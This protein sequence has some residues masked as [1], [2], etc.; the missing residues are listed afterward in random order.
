MSWQFD[1]AIFILSSVGRA[2]L[3]PIIH[4]LRA[5]LSTIPPAKIFSA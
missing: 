2:G 4:E 3:T 1:K 5:L